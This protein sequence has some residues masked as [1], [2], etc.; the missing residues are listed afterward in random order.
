[1]IIPFLG[2]I[3]LRFVPKMELINIDPYSIIHSMGS[4]SVNQPWL[5]ILII[6]H[7]SY[8]YTYDK[9]VRMSKPKFNMV[10]GFSV[11]LLLTP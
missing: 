9:L 1:M 5:V 2:H 11:S 7:K 8:A 10:L 3:Q 6:K 4:G